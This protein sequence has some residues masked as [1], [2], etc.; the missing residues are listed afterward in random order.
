MTEDEAKAMCCPFAAGF[1]ASEGTMNEYG[2]ETRG[3]LPLG[4][5]IGSACMAWRE[6]VELLGY[7]EA[8]R[9]GTPPAGE[10]WE[11]SSYERGAYER[12]AR[13]KSG[14]FC[15][16]AGSPSQSLEHKDAA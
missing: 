3:G 14:G 6:Q 11:P 13:R 12:Q 10:G 4:R 7:R 1:A 8:W 5:C 9:D 15:G 16:L 2:R